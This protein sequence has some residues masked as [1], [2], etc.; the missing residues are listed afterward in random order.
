MIKIKRFKIHILILFVLSWL[1]QKA[2]EPTVSKT[3]AEP[4]PRLE[5]AYADWAILDALF[6][7]E[8]STHLF[9]H[10]KK[11]SHVSCIF[12]ICYVRT[13]RLHY[14]TLPPQKKCYIGIT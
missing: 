1:L 4:K 10:W 8:Y 7:E 14:Y 9:V 2:P 13:G 12:I 11:V 6:D 5:L 3:A